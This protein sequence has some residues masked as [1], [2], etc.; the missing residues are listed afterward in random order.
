MNGRTTRRGEATVVDFW[1][2]LRRSTQ[3]RIGLGHSGDGMPT[4]ERLALREA[5]ALAR[6]AIAT[7]LDLPLLRDDLAAVG[8]S[9]VYEV[10][11]Q[12]STRDEYVRR[13]DLGRLPADLSGLPQG[14]FDIGIVLADGL[15]PRAVSDH[16]ALMVGALLA[17]LPSGLSM[18]PVV[19]ATNARVALGDHIGAALGVDTVFVLIGER[20]G[21]SVADSLGIY[22]THRP[23]PGRA[24]SERNCISNVHPPDG[25]SY[26]AAAATASRLL[27]SARMLGRSGV[28]VKDTGA[29]PALEG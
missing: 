28:D 27:G 10:T 7:P 9:E 19:I 16:G 8:A 14:R 23:E 26:A 6:D 21:L 17:A 15:S 20:P 12:A 1:A 5:L 11:S 18:A 24:D 4:G 13:P 2:P 29:D 25:N 3:A 22:M